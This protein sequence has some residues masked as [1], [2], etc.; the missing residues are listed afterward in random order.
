MG[1]GPGFKSRIEEHLR[2]WF[3]ETRPDLKET[4]D[5][6]L[7]ALW[8]REVIIPLMHLTEEHEPSDDPVPGVTD[9]NAPRSS[10]SA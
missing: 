4:L 9:V 5:E 10:V 2:T 6:R 7:N 8:E 1:Q 3:D